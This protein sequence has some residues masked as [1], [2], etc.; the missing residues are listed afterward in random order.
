MLGS[1]HLVD[2]AIVVAY[3]AALTAVGVYFSR[4]QASLDDFFRARQRMSWLPVGLSLMA[5][6]NSGIDY[7]MQPSATIKYGLVLLVGTSS[8][9]FLYPWVSRVTLPFYRRLGVFT[10]AHTCYTCST[11][12]VSPPV[13]Y[14]VNC[15][16]PALLS[17]FRA[18]PL[19]SGVELRWQFGEAGVIALQPRSGNVD[20][21]RGRRH[22]DRV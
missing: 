1:V 5:A 22:V 9:L 3:L 17:L 11:H 13:P 7:L 18:V 20:R 21:H 2:A 16:T 19:V 10:A 14:E 15:P 6:L 8:W 12:V 4:R